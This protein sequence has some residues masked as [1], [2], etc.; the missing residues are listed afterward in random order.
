[1]SDISF[2]LG[3]SSS[4]KYSNAVLGFIAMWKTKTSMSMLHKKTKVHKR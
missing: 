1:M 2:T 4:L 3:K